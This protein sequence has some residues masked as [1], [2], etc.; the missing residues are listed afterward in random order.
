[1]GPTSTQTQ[2]KGLHIHQRPQPHLHPNEE[3]VEANTLSLLVSMPADQETQ[4]VT[5]L[6][7]EILVVIRMGRHFNKGYSVFVGWRSL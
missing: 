3:R 7:N 1:M 5:Q 4:W 2:T 6:Y